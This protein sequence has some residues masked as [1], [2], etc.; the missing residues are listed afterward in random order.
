MKRIGK[1]SLGFP[2]YTDNEIKIMQLTA[3]EIL[4]A[5]HKVGKWADTEMEKAFQKAE[6]EGKREQ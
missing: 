4:E 2:L 1:R 5:V 6:K 3:K